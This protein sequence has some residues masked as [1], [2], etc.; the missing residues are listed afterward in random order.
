MTADVATER[1]PCRLQAPLRTLT[2]P[3]WESCCCVWRESWTFTVYTCG[4][5]TR[6]SIWFLPT[7][8]QV[9]EENHR[10]VASE[11][12]DDV[13]RPDDLI[14]FAPCVSATLEFS[15]KETVKWLDLRKTDS[16][17]VDHIKHTCVAPIIW[18]HSCDRGF[19]WSPQSR[20]WR[21]QR[22][23]EKDIFRRFCHFF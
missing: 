22:F 18:T 17:P 13:R 3:P 11:I 19:F 20:Y 8:L 23:Y 15:R 21:I 14:V 12:Q 16:Y 9:G 7:W 1:P 6:A 4:A 2:S 10:S 5:S